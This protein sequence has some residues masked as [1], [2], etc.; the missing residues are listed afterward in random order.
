VKPYL[1]KNSSQKS[2]GKKKRFFFLSPNICLAHSLAP[3]QPSFI[4]LWKL[5]L[6]TSEGFFS[7]CRG[8]PDLELLGSLEHLDADVDVA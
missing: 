8:Q 1:E 6:P 5:P 4:F 7:F 2:T 3:P